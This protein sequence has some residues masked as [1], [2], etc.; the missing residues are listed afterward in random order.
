MKIIKTKPEKP[1]KE[2]IKNG[3]NFNIMLAKNCSDEEKQKTKRKFAI[4]KL[5]YLTDK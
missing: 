2:A 1:I 3:D 5:K 4:K